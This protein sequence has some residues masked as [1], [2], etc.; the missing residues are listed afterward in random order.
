VIV[1]VFHAWGGGSFFLGIIRDAVLSE[2]SIPS[3]SKS[4]WIR[5]A[6]HSGLATAILRIDS[7]MLKS[8]FGLPAFWKF[9]SNATGI[10]SGASR[11]LFPA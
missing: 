5:G 11:S 9:W 7:R 8:Q 2:M 6:S 1:E 10:F 3:F 4:P